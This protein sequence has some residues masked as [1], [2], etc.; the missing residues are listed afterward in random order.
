MVA[1]AASL[2]AERRCGW[3]GASVVTWLPDWVTE[4]ADSI[5]AVISGRGWSPED[6]DLGGRPLGRVAIRIAGAGLD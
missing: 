3:L 1:T 6:L 5:C 2:R 4:N